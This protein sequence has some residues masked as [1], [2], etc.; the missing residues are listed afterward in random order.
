R[1][2]LEGQGVALGSVNGTLERFEAEAKTAMLVAVDGQIAGV[3]AV[4]DTVKDGSAEAIRQVRD[5][6]LEVV[7]IT[8]DNAR[9]AEAIGRQV[10]ISQVLAEVLPSDKAERV[11]AKNQW[12]DDQCEQNLDTT[13]GSHGQRK[14]TQTGQDCL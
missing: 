6:G 3:V 13:K 11:V 4:A 2:L 10:G 8:G 9:T 1:R 5:L 7:M 14:F 12:P